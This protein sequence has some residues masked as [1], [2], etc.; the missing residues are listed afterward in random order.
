MRT[1]LFLF[2]AEKN[3]NAEDGKDLI[4]RS[5]FVITFFGFFNLFLLIY[6]RIRIVL[7]TQNNPHYMQAGA[8]CKHYAAYD[9]E[10]NG[11]LPSRVFF[12]VRSPIVVH[13]NN[14]Q[15][16]TYTVHCI[17]VLQYLCLPVFGCVVLLQSFACFVLTRP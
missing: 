9:L 17:A 13:N 4:R 7:G 12:D 1:P 6:L 15:P 8:C 14:C 16:H 10:G 5:A 11:P 3:M 2:S